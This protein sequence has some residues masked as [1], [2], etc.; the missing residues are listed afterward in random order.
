VVPS[1][2]EVEALPVELP[3]E[4]LLVF[5]PVALV[6]DVFSDPP[7]TLVVHALP[8]LATSSSETAATEQR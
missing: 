5:A 7:S 2:L 8:K 6:T 4:A 3:P 1:W